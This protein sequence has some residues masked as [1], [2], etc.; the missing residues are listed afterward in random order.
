MFNRVSQNFKKFEFLDIELH[1]AVYVPKKQPKKFQEFSGF[2]Q[3][4]PSLLILQ[5]DRAK[6]TKEKI[7]NHIF[8]MYGK[9]QIV[10]MFQNPRISILLSETLLLIPIMSMFVENMSYAICHNMSK[11]V[12]LWLIMTYGVQHIFNKH[13]HDGYQ[14]NRI[15]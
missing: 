2:F 15:G 9:N 11:N 14:K 3:E 8:T 1:T 5:R 10:K 12:I 7:K 4:W 6:N 13:G